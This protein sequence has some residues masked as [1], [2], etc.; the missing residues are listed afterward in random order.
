[1][2]KSL[3]KFSFVLLMG[4]ILFHLTYNIMC[5]GQE[6]NNK[7]KIGVYD[8]RVIVMAYSRSQLFIDYQKKLTLPIDSGSKN[9]SK[10]KEQSV[11]AISF[12]HLLHQMVFS[13][14]SAKDIVKMVG[15]KLPELAK[16]AGVIMIVSKFETDYLD[17]SVEKIDVTT[18][19]SKL[20]NPLQDISKMA[21]EIQKT[22]PVPMFELTIEMEMF[23]AY[24]EKFG[25]K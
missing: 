7:V 14:G 16:K 8:S 23:D 25:K 12:Q 13:N 2:N 21:G 18:E 4:F 5:Y 20:F 3:I 22:S 24:C 15:D 19:V 9:E 17:P 6:K 10:Q 1:M 11:K